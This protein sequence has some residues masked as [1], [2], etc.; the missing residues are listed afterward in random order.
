MDLTGLTIDSARSAVAERKTSALALA[1]AFYAKIETDDQK[2]GAYLILSH[3][4]GL[5]KAA[6][7]GT[8]AT[9]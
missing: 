6:Q 1:E 5:E 9:L 2:I 4:R 3:E 8:L 7:R